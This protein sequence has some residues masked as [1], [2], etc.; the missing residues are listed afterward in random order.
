MSKLAAGMTIAMVVLALVA[1]LTTANPI[2]IKAAD[3]QP[4]LREFQR[5]LKRVPFPFLRRHFLPGMYTLIIIRLLIPFRNCSILDNNNMRV[6]FP[7]NSSDKLGHR[8]RIPVT[9]NVNQ[10]YQWWEVGGTMR[11]GGEERWKGLACEWCLSQTDFSRVT[12]HPP[13]HPPQQ[14]GCFQK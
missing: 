12:P 14:L 2:I 11:R 8:I 4:I 10:N 3:W 6:E 1:L 9:P 5:L 13:P 7:L